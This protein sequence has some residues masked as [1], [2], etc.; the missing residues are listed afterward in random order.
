MVFAVLVLDSRWNSTNK[1][2]LLHSAL[3]SDAS[4][5]KLGIFGSH[6][7]HSWPENTDELITRF[8]DARKIDFSQLADDSSPNKFEALNT[9]IGAFLHE[10]GHA[11]G[12]G[13]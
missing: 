4:N 9:G 7:T 6:L 8:T 5:P 13:K 2:V 1:K 3:G 10:L 12:L 11:F